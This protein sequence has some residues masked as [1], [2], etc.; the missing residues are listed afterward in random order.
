MNGFNSQDF[1][2]EQVNETELIGRIT[3][4]AQEIYTIQTDTASYQATV[5]GKLRHEAASTSIWPAVGDWVVYQPHDGDKA[6]IQRVLQRRTVLSRRAAGPGI[7]EQVIAANVDTVFIVSTLTKE[8]NVQRIERYVMQVYESG[9]KPV[10]VC[11]KRD[12]CEDVMDKQAQIERHAPGVPIYLVNNM[13]G[14]GIEE[15]QNELHERDTISLIGSSGV[16]KSTLMNRLIGEDIQ[17]TN[18]VREKDERGLHTTTHRELFALPNGT[19]VIDTPGMRELQLWGDATHVD[20]TF[21][22]IDELSEQ[23]KFR[24][25]QHH[26]EPGCAVIAAIEAGELTSERLKNYQKML[27]EVERLDLK[28]KYGTH[29]ANRI[30][31][32]PRAR[33]S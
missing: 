8:F 1:F 31:H 6:Q 22:D 11:T 15:L 23:C 24:D 26:Q 19:Y 17:V 32:S 25:C 29:R 30:L 14:S 33:K 13:D 27:R 10:I 21:S 7:D 5:S 3:R 4:A 2:N 9:A 16:G 12:L 28:N 20:T 18:E